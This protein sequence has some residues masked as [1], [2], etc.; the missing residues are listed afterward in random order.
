L[1]SQHTA[2]TDTIIAT[3]K[4]RGF[5][6]A[7]INYLKSTTTSAVTKQQIQ[8]AITVWARDKIAAAP[9]PLYI[10]MIDHGLPAGFVLDSVKLTP[11]DLKS[12]LDTLES[13]P[14]VIASGALTNFNRFIII[15]SCYSG[16]FISKLSKP[17]RIVITSAAPD[18]ESLAGVNVFGINSGALYGG[19]YFVD[20]LF[21]FLG[22]GDTFKDAFNAATRAVSIRDPRVRLPQK[23]YYGSYD[24]LAQHPLLDDNGD[25]K[26]S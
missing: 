2:T 1:L 22:R 21:G 14:A 25:A 13:A 18:E 4:K 26:A 6:D 16:S 19:E 7:N 5:L 8:N 17:G 15:G 11:D 12:Y 23:Y 20:T 10:V 9:A 3:L 24:T